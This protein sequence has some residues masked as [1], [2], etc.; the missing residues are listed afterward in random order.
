MRRQM[1]YVAAAAAALAVV[2]FTA[3][4][5]GGSGKGTGGREGGGQLISES[6]ML[7][8]LSSGALFP[9]IDT[10]PNRIARAHIAVTDATASC[11]SG[12]APPANIQV[13]VGEA[14]VALVGVMTAAT[15]TG[16][17]TP[18]Q[19]VFHVTVRPRRGG[20]PATVTDIVVRNA[21]TAPLTGI[22]TVT[23]SATVKNR[24]G[25]D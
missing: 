9:F 13:L 7:A 22:N 6:S 12:A 17:G 20:V 25:E 24:G 4:A 11:S 5:A 16:I 8:G 14:G 23:A 2:A 3:T 21:G 1:L 10:T 15:N 19:C 18:A